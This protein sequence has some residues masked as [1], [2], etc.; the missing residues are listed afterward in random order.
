MPEITATI[1]N[2]FRTAG[3]SFIS[4]QQISRTLGISRTAVWKHIKLLRLQGF[5][6]E[7]VT[8]RGYHL[9]SA[10]N[11]LSSALIKE[12]LTSV[13]IGSNII[14]HD[15]TASTNADA[16]RLAEEGAREGTTVVADSQNN[17]KGRLGRIWSS[18]PGVNLYC[19]I[20]LRPQIMP[21][22]APQLTFLS[23][24]AVARAIELTTTLQPKIKWPNDILLNDCKIAGLLNE[25]SAE[26]DG[27]KFVV[28]GIGVNLNM[29]EEQFPHDLRTPATSLF[30]EQHKPVQRAQFTAIMLNELD[31]LYTDFKRF[32]FEPVRE[33]WQARSAAN[34]RQVEITDGGQGR[35]R[36]DFAGIDE[37]GSML[38]RLDN[39]IV[40]RIYSGDVRVL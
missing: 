21:F 34:G 3:D 24:V 22:E 14:Y 19:S 39:G 27:V 4:G 25:M 17:G 23:A 10:P 20:I 13:V 7:A 12:Q 1:L 35:I 9:V 31:R 11:S 29:T 32:G 36:G 8:S 16:F 5:E 33:E 30:I 37:S 6:I 18:P 38:V 2:L 40:E 15:T 26:T 28:L